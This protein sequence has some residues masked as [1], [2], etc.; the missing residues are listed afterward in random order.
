MS[1]APIEYPHG[2][3]CCVDLNSHD[4]KAAAAWYGELFGW[5]VDIRQMP[6]APPYGI[7]SLQERPVA[8]IGEMSAEMKAQGIPPLWNSYVAVDDAAA[9]ERRVA[10]LGGKVLHPATKAGEFGTA[11]F[12]ADPSGAVFA[13]WQPGIY[14]GAQLTGPNTWCWCELW[15]HDVAA[16]RQFYGQ[17][18]GWQ[19]KTDGGSPEYTECMVGDHAVGGMIKIDGHVGPPMWGVYF[20][21]ADIDATVAR[22]TGT[23]G[24]LL[25]GPKTID[26]VGRFCVVLD[27]QGGCFSLIQMQ[28]RGA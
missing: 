21:V 11:A 17:L 28:H 2:G 5:R 14:K 23:G 4:M 22:V 20:E 10:E 13:V 26:N 8:G 25:M 27:P 7:F 16:S 9:I 1:T 24:R 19:F 6:G 12:F 15:S 18:F 3:F